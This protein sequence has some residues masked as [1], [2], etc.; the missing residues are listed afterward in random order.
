[1]MLIP[2]RFSEFALES[3]NRRG[4]DPNRGRNKP[5]QSETGRASSQDDTLG[6]L[7]DIVAQSRGI[8]RLRFN[9]RGGSGMAAPIH[10]DAKKAEGQMEG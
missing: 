1:M 8:Q 9:R 5:R 7:G 3:L 10:L 4:W 2:W 6:W